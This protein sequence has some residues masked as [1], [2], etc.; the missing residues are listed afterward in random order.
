MLAAM[1]PLPR[2]RRRDGAIRR[3]VSTVQRHCNTNQPSWYMLYTAHRC[4][5]TTVLPLPCKTLRQRDVTNAGSEVSE[6]QTIREPARAR[7]QQPLFLGRF[8]CLSLSGISDNALYELRRDTAYA[9]L[10]FVKR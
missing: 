5:P 3:A 7:S 1:M 6:T 8:V 4:T 9:E 2:R 10:Q